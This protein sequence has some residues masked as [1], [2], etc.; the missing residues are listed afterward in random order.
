MEKKHMAYEVIAALVIYGVIITLA[1]APLWTNGSRDENITHSPPKG[2]RLTPH[3]GSHIGGTFKETMIVSAGDSVETTFW[4][5][6]KGTTHLEF[7]GWSDELHPLK[8][9]VKPLSPGI[10]IEIE[11]NPVVIKKGES[12]EVTL[13]IKT[14]PELEPGI[15]WIQGYT[16]LQGIDR[17]V[18][19]IKLEVTEG[20]N[21]QP[22]EYF[23]VDPI[24]ILP[25]FFLLIGGLLVYF[26]RNKSK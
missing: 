7:I 26:K 10:E 21:G 12:K 16:V 2:E 13:M 1:N 17:Q 23:M 18:T 20:I 4:A 22:S 8:S 11:P 3:P 5:T 6:H 24:Y 25:L 15:Y 19:K 14:S 9:D